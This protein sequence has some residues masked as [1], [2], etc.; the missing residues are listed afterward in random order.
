MTDIQQKI[1]SLLKEDARRGFEEV[2]V[3]L[4][5]DKKAAAKEIA[6]LEKAGVIVKYTALINENDINSQKVEALIEVKVSPLKTK[7]FDAIADEIVKFNE[8]KSLSLMSG[9][10]DLM[11]IAEGD[12]LRAVANFVS[13]KL[14]TLEGVLSTATHFVLKKYKPE[15]VVLQGNQ[16]EKRL[17]VQP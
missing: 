7:G 2:A 8:V 3:L 5:L 9:A 11:V 12:S 4:G 15:D 17:L 16:N 13:E 6:A 1:I 14:S 10:Y